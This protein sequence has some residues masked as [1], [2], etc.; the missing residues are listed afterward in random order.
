[1]SINQFF[2]LLFS[3]S[4]CEVDIEVEIEAMFDINVRN[5]V[6]ILFINNLC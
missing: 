1:M 5:D 6:S 4:Q 2:L 3:R